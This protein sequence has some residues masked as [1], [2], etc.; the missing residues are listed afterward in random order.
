MRKILSLLILWPSLSSAQESVS[1]SRPT[2]VVCISFH[3]V[4]TP[5]HKPQNNFRN[6]GFKFGIEIPWNNKDNLR[7]SVELGYYFNRLNG[8]SIYAHSDFV[9]RPIIRG[10]VRAD[11]RIGPGLGFLLAPRK[12]LIQKDGLWTSAQGGKWFPQVHGA[13]GISYNDVELESVRIS[14]FVQYEVMAIA[15]YN[16]GIPVLP[17][18]FIHIGSKAKF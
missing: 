4:S 9:Y 8:R 11:F 2:F 13:V 15:G 7:Q 17:N 3:A 16:R 10:N 14:P 1:N 18:S 12:T 5:L 6:L